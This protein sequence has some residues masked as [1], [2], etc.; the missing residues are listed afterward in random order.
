MVAAHLQSTFD[1]ALALRAPPTL[2]ITLRMP[3]KFAIDTRKCLFS[4]NFLGLMIGRKALKSLTKTGFGGRLAP[5]PLSLCFYSRITVF[6]EFVVD[7]A[8]SIHAR[9]RLAFMQ[10]NKRALIA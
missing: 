2:Q 9:D 1:F 8:D 3:R 6:P 7:S 10:A 5:R 4:F